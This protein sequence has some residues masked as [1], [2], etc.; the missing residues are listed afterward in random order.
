[1]DG[2]RA[3]DAGGV[4]WHVHVSG[5]GPVA[6]LL[7]GTGASADS[8]GGLVPL[9]AERFTVIVPDLPGHARSSTPRAAGMS[10]D[11][12][13]ASTAALLAALDAQPAIAIGHSAGAAVLARM[14]LDGR[15]SLQSLIGLNAALMPL[16]G[17]LRVLSPM[18]KLLARAPG[19]ARVVSGFARD[20]RAVA[21]LVDGTGSKLDAA[22]VGRYAALVRD[23]HHVDGAIAM[24][25]AW[26]LD[27]TWAEL[28]RLRPAP[29]LIVGDHDRTIP[30]HQ[31]RRVAA[32]VPGT[33]VVVMPGL[34]HLAHEEDPAGTA[35]IVFAHA[36]G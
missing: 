24:M 13:A 9:L 35:T 12:M 17:L 25:A 20:D 27:R 33:K 21:R 31:A 34:G 7:H 8:F 6:L 11:G 29:L 3:L 10:V 26:N 16:D 28:P 36:M 1:M 4:R 22:G 2:G 15:L 19:F 23:R 30:P 32:H 14:A 5:S 18:A